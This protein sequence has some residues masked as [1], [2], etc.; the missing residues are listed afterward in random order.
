LYEKNAAT[1]ERRAGPIHQLII[2]EPFF[3]GG[4]TP[5]ASDNRCDIPNTGGG[6]SAPHPETSHLAGEEAGVNQLIM[7]ATTAATMEQVTRGKPRQ[8]VR[9]EA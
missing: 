2:R 4:A 7:R 3:S 5:L 8:S 9:H 6:P 1:A